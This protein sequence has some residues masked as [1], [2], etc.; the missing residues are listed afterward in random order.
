MIHCDLCKKKVNNQYN[1]L[2][3]LKQEFWVGGVQD[4]CSECL[5]KINKVYMERFKLIEVV[6]EI[7]NRKVKQTIEQLLRGK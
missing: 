6:D 7:V 3:K 4:V 1:D 5:D 2:S